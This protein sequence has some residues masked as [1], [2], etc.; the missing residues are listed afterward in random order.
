MLI[1]SFEQVAHGKKKLAVGKEPGF[2]EPRNRVAFGNKP[3][4]VK[5]PERT[6]VRADG[7]RVFGSHPP[8][9]F[10]VMFLNFVEKHIPKRNKGFKK[11][12]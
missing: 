4:T 10:T 3:T 12:F 5:R 8:F 2:C 1:S 7:G 9:G 6:S 11:Y